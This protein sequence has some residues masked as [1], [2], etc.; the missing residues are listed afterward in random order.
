M[1]QSNKLPVGL[2]YIDANFIYID[3]PNVV[4]KTIF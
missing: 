4:E 2:E 1:E 3:V